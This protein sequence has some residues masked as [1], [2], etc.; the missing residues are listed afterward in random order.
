M[1]DNREPLKNFKQRNDRIRLA[2]DK[3]SYGMR[4]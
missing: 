4:R 1:E 3:A 2:F